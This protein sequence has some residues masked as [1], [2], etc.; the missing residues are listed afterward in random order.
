M[1]LPLLLVL[2]L[3]LLYRWYRQSRL[4]ENITDKYVFITGCDTGF[5]NLL[6]KQLDKRGMRVLAA[7]LTETGVKNLKK[8]TSSRL[9]TTILDVANAKSVS[10]AALW[11]EENV[12]NKGL[13]G[14]VNNAGIGLPTA[15]NSWLGREDF[16]KVLNVNLLGM[17]DVTLNLL[18]LIRR[19]RGRIINMSSVMGRL[20]FVGGGYSISRFG[21]EAFSDSL[22]RELQRFGVKVCIIEPS[23]FRTPATDIQTTLQSLNDVW[24]Q[25][26]LWAKE[27]YGQKYF[28]DYCRF[29]KYRLSK[30]DPQIYRVTDSIE[31]AL[32]SVNPWTRY[33]VGWMAKLYFIPV[34]YLPTFIS[35]Y[36]LAHPLETP[37]SLYLS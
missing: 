8:E 5:G 18:P 22:R 25:A 26:P 7:C 2:G 32:T 23:S 27:S 37:S 16:V 6:A 24:R 11:V 30:C 29:I 31:H 13:W 15:P 12:K 21:V 20:A 1:C 33:S 3:I 19:A 4:M 14:L 10:S 28:Q 34:S 9:Q 36:L 17:I 35:D